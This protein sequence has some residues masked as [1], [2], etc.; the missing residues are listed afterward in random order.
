MAEPVF[1]WKGVWDEGAFGWQEF[2]GA[3]SGE[4]MPC[5]DLTTEDVAGFSELQLQHLDS[6]A[7]RRLYEGKRAGDEARTEPVNQPGEPVDQSS[8]TVPPDGGVIA[9]APDQPGDSLPDPGV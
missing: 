6:P 9:V 2:F 7:G 5:R 3:D 4:P 1:V 8:G